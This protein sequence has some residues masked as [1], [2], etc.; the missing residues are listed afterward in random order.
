MTPASIEELARQ[1][2]I[3][4]TEA[5]MVIDGE[6]GGLHVRKLARFAALVR[7]KALVEAGRGFYI[8]C[9]RDNVETLASL[10]V[11][12]GAWEVKC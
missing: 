5:G 6:Y 1:A 4:I 7:A 11:P 12:P 2:G 10:D 3:A 8:Q 9:G